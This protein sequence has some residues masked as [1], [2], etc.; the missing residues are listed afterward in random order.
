MNCIDCGKEIAL[1]VYHG[2]G[3]HQEGP[4]CTG[5]AQERAQGEIEAQN[6][7]ALSDMEMASAMDDQINRDRDRQRQ[8]HIDHY[9]ERGLPVPNSCY[10]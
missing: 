6:E 2:T 4:F 5:C 8:R 7:R 3:F 9:T 1:P 10:K